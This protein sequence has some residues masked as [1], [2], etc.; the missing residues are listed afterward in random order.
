[1]ERIYLLEPGTFLKKEGTNL[2]LTRDGKVIDRVSLD[3]L[4][5]LTLIGYTSLSGAVLRA[6][7]RNRIE[8]VLLTPT[9][10]FEGR[11]CVDEH[12]QVLRRKAQY[13]RLSDPVMQAAVAESIVK[14]KLR[15]QARL[16]LLRGQQFGE[17]TLLASGAAIRALE[18][19]FPS[20]MTD[21]DFIRGVEG[22][23]SRIYFSAFPD[24]LRNPDFTFPG[25]VKRPPTD[26][27]NALLSFVYSVL[28]NEVLSAIQR[29]GL[30]PYLGS[31]H[32]VSYGRPSLACDLVEEW[33]AFIADRLVLGLL[34]RKSI[35]P[36]NFVYR[37]SDQKVFA[38]EEELKARRPVEMKPAT[39]RALLKAYD[40]WM[41]TRVLDPAD[42]KKTSYREILFAQARRF[43]S[44]IMGE[45]EMYLP[46]AWDKVR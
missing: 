23:G 45:S 27:V 12:K 42:G 26:P 17:P 6:L 24:M 46:F 14:G 38:D 36:D 40:A 37:P 25:R 15:S 19:G 20:G 33:R 4:K 5:Q 8:T 22:H 28:T 2:A 31:L 29:V 43:N 21:L 16:L 39:M 11:L 10:R 41:N 35:S 18:K 44:W 7:V 3:G 30:D 9:G 32:E 1:M 34:N 13:L